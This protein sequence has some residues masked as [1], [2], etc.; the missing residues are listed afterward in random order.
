MNQDE[1]LMDEILNR[2]LRSN[3]KPPQ[4]AVPSPR[5]GGSVTAEHA[6]RISKE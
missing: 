6:P 4:Q 5:R 3:P 2:I 1:K